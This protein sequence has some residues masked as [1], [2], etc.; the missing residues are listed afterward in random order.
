MTAPEWRLLWRTRGLALDRCT[1]DALAVPPLEPDVLRQRIPLTVQVPDQT[2]RT[3][4]TEADR[5]VVYDVAQFVSGFMAECLPAQLVATDARPLLPNVASK[6]AVQAVGDEKE[7]IG[8]FDAIIRIR[9]AIEE[10]NAWRRWNMCDGAVDIKMTGAAEPFGLNSPSMR[11][12]LATGRLVM[13]AARKI[14]DNP[15]GQCS[16]VAWL[17]RRPRGPTFSSRGGKVHGGA[18]AFLAFD[19]SSTS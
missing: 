8:S 12:W 13:K 4:L 16:F 1:T 6:L 5:D 17:I 18:Y 14:K 3:K 11:R 2:S 7:F 19:A 9:A 10:A 15:V